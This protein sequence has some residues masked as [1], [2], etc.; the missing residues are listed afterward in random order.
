M[1]D[2]FTK[3]KDV[4]QEMKEQIGVY[5]KLLNFANKF[6]PSFMGILFD[7]TLIDCKNFK[8]NGYEILGPQSELPDE[9]KSETD[10][11]SFVFTQPQ[12]SKDLFDKHIKSLIFLVKCDFDSK[13][14][15]HFDNTHKTS[16]YLYKISDYYTFIV[17]F[18]MSRQEAK[19]KVVSMIQEIGNDLNLSSIFL[20][21]NQN[22]R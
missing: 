2:S 21:F 17:T 20:S 15:Y 12:I 16:Y 22:L 5:S 8:G 3:L 13:V 11:Y 1:Y 14:K 10:L 4:S 7:S 18:E 6:S 19:T 9:I